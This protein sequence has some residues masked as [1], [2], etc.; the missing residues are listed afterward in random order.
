MR[1]RFP[2]TPE[3]VSFFST[4]LCLS[5]R[6]PASM[7]HTSSTNRHWASSA[8]IML[9]LRTMLLF[10]F[11][12]VAVVHGL[13]LPGG[14]TGGSSD[15]D[16]TVSVPDMNGGVTMFHRRPSQAETKPPTQNKKGGTNNQSGTAGKPVRE[17]SLRRRTRERVGSPTSA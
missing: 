12:S 1:V 16:A 15:S 10:L 9:F 13:P 14:K 3:P 17:D 5:V 6:N 11:T 8:S 2:H 4:S 7:A